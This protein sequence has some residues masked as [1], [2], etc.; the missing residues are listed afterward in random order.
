[1]LFFRSSEDTSSITSVP[2]PETLFRQPRNGWSE[3]RPWGHP[4]LRGWWQTRYPLS[5]PPDSLIPCLTQA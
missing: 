1:T 3:E 4:H 2:N 5:P